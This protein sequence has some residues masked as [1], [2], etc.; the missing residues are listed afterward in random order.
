MSLVVSV[1]LLLLL[2]P[3]SAVFAVGYRTLAPGD[4]A[5]DLEM[6]ETAIRQVHPDPFH[7]RGV[8]AFV[9]SFIQARRAAEEPMDAAAFYYLA[10]SL[11]AL[12]EDSNTTLTFEHEP[13][14]L[15]VRFWWA[16]DQLVVAGA[17]ARTG[18]EPGWTVLAVSGLTAAEIISR[19]D[20]LLPTENE[21]ALK[22]RTARLLHSGSFLNQVGAA[23]SGYVELV[24]CRGEDEYLELI[25]ELNVPVTVDTVRPKR[26][27]WGWYI[28]DEEDIAVFYLDSTDDE[29][30][31][32]L[33]L[34]RFF[35][36]V[37]AYGIEHIVL[38]LR[39]NTASDVEVIPEFLRYFPEQRIEGYAGEIRYS[40]QAAQQ[41]GYEETMGVE[42]VSHLTRLFG[43]YTMNLPPRPQDIPAYEGQFYVL[44][45]PMT[46]GSAHWFA[47]VIQ[48]NQLGIVAGEPTGQRPTGYGDPLQFSLPNSGFSL[49]V[50]HKRYVR[51]NPNRDPSDSLYPDWPL[52]IT[53][54]D[55]GHA[56]DL[57]LQELLRRIR[58]TSQ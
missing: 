57:Q 54:C 39:W 43:G 52:P 11:A 51:P 5:D 23:D 4:M 34:Q 15:P 29:S 55:V 42:R 58:A 26:P 1:L 30:G 41:R 33:A 22:N 7:A 44:T 13:N 31:Y 19:A 17:A 37:A 32:R 36:A 14:E 35:R 45:S 8:D 46:V 48:D 38:D 20:S 6:L 2:I 47:V 49:L 18:L 12:V 3:S 10:L 53:A 56:E 40:V 25:V 28:V 9:R 21:Y 27:A 50:S 24:L 16:E